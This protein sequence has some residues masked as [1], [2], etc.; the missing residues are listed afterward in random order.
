MDLRDAKNPALITHQSKLDIL[1]T[2]AQKHVESS[3]NIHYSD[4][5][6]PNIKVRYPPQ[7]NW[8]F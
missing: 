2:S 7:D 4:P 3:G 6:L 1:K 5:V 8:E